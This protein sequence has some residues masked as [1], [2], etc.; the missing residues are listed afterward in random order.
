MAAPAFPKTFQQFADGIRNLAANYLLDLS[1][2]KLKELRLIQK[3][4]DETPRE[5]HHTVPIF[6]DYPIKP[7]PRFGHDKPRHPQLTAILEAGRDGYRGIVREILAH[8]Q[9]FLKIPTHQAAAPNGPYWKNG[10]QPGLDAAALFTML[11]RCGGKRYLEVGS[12]NSTRFARHA[13]SQL[14]L[15]MRIISIDP[16]PRAEIDAIC[17]EVIRAPL[18]DCDL[19]IF[20]TL[21]SGDVLFIDNSHRSF[22]NS[23]VTICFLEILPRLKKGVYVQIHDIVLP[24]DYPASWARRYYSEQYLLACY[25][26]GGGKGV[27]I[28]LPNAYVG[29][30]AELGGMLKALW[31]QLPDVE[32]HGVSFWLRTC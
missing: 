32:P 29:W 22:M 25:L 5:P 14:E 21:E 30:D 9:H 18:E 3:L 8:T 13:I 1:L 24:D 10:T 26:L 7:A 16:Q 27:Q 11:G 17:D 6:L 2:V 19:A 28:V 23:D 31:N 4:V 12:G 20:D 15:P